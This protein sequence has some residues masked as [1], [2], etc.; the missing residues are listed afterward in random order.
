MKFAELL[1]GDWFEWN[2]RAYIRLKDTIMSLDRRD[3]GIL[4]PPLWENREVKYITAFD[5]QVKPSYAGCGNNEVSIKGAPIEVLLEY[6]F[7]G[8]FYVKISPYDPD[9]P[10]L[11]VIRAQG[12][13][14]GSLFYSRFLN[15]KVRIV[16]TIH[17]QNYE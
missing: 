11:V 8:S 1:T 2:E 14:Q 16:D 17:L 12:D 15:S 7:T 3:F 6:P 10:D 5:Y 13:D 9:D 4:Y